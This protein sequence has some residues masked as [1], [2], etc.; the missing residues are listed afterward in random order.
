MSHAPTNIPALSLRQLC[1][2]AQFLGCDDIVVRGAKIDSRRIGPGDLFVAISGSQENGLAYV[3]QAIANGATA[4]LTEESGTQL[5]VDV[6]VG[7]VSNTR[8]AWA[9]ICDAT[10]GSPSQNLQIT[11]ITGTNGK[12]TV[13]WLLRSILQAASLNTGLLGTIEYDNGINVRPAPLTTPTSVELQ[14]TLAEMVDNHCSHAVME[15][16]SHALDQHRAASTE[17]AAAVVTNVTQDHFDYHGCFE[18]YVRAKQRIFD[19]CKHDAVIALNADDPGCQKML[20]AVSED[21]VTTYGFS[22]FSDVCG[23]VIDSAADGTRFRVQS[24]AGEFEIRTPLVGQHNVQNC[25]AAVTVALG[26]GITPQQIVEG[27]ARLRNV[28]G[29]MEHIDC[30]QPFNV[31]V[32][33]A[34]TPDAIAHSV[35]TTRSLT[36]GR[37]IC[38]CGAG[39]DRDVSKRPLIGRAASDA[40]C[41]IVTSDNPR[42]ED[43]VDIIENIVVGIPART[44]L[45][46]HPDRTAAIEFALQIARP[47]DSVLIAGKGHETTQELA[48]ET[49][50]FD[51]RVVVRTVLGQLKN[52]Q[53][54]NQ[55]KRFAA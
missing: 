12:T 17:L 51:D 32:D 7:I 54:D 5:Q 36:S 39:G 21:R 28:P 46:T 49:V 25:L 16:S 42:S 35:K 1:P 24:S 2:S 48:N 18:N 53:S 19:L 52:K 55:P 11:G 40:D 44:D 34:H 14:R 30:G 31:Y 13:A 9:Q 22:K 43:P 6:P 37:V 27:I 3:D 10:F 20:T 50:P 47:G 38:V 41:V 29:R 33:Y 23:R 4:I 45:H 15:L 8:T 26:M